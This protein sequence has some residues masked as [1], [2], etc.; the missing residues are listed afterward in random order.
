MRRLETKDLYKV[1]AFT[2]SRGQLVASQ[3]ASVAGLVL[4]GLLVMWPH[5][6]LAQKPLPT[7][8][9]SM[10]AERALQALRRAW[11]DEINELTSTTRSL[12][13]SDDTYDFVAR[14]N[15]PYVYDHYDRKR[16]ARDRIDTVLII[17]RH[18]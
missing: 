13:L 11:V 2:T 9:D 5:A 14:P 1:C 16:L 3:P 6:G 15:L 18:R 12:A 8:V 17:N 10:P 4:V 7:G